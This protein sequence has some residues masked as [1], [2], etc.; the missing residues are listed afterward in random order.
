MPRDSHG[1]VA[2][3]ATVGPYIHDDFDLKV[4][5]KYTLLIVNCSTPITTYTYP[6]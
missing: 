4:G 6:K 3:A 5:V 1:V 2:Y